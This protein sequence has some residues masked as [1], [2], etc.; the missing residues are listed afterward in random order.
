MTVT[1]GA[2]ATSLVGSSSVHS[3]A[4][5]IAIRTRAAGRHEILS[6]GLLGGGALRDAPLGR[7]EA[8]LA[9]HERGGVEVDRL[10]DGGEDAVAD[11][12]V[13]DLRRG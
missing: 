11:E 12:D 4:L 9:R 3:D 13:D 10:V 1:I 6:G 5:A 8:E 7:L 2:R